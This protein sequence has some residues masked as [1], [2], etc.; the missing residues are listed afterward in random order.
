MARGRKKGGLSVNNINDKSELTKMIINQINSLNKKIKKFSENGIDEHSEYVHALLNNERM[1]KFTENGTISKSKAFYQEQN[2]IWLK[3]TLSALHKIN[4]NNTL[5]TVKKYEKTVNDTIRKIQDT[6][7]QHLRSKGYSE[8]FIQEIVNDKDYIKSLISAFNEGGKGYG[9]LQIVEKVALTY[10]EQ[11][12]SEEQKKIL[13][14][15]EGS[16]NALDEI[17]REVAEIEEARK[18]LR[19]RNNKMR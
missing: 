6:I 10:K 3:K 9:S 19:Q 17:K 8:Q 14:N 18:L 11:D 13:N 2:T 16:K 7:K 12:L 15:I 1:A 4:N 5:G